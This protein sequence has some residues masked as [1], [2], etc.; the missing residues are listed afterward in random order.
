MDYRELIGILLTWTPYLAE[1][2]TWNVIISIVSMLLG[3]AIG[4]GIAF[5]RVSGAGLLAR[6]AS[7]FTEIC[8]NI[9]TFVFLFYLAFLL[10]A[11][12]PL[13]LGLYLPV[14]AWFKASLALSVAVVGYISDTL[15]NAI[16]DKRQGRPEAMFLFLPAWMTYFLIIVMAS[17][18]A[19]VIG[20]GEVVSR[21]NTVIS[22][23]G[24]QDL[25]VW[26]YVYV[27]SWFFL[28]CWPLAMLM[29]WVQNRIRNHPALMP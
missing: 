7:G 2:F 29:R 6:G 28:F 21:A 17:S 26:I 15:S 3:T 11:E 25:M 24:R 12:V 16:L 14:P 18:T 8:R 20:V 19:S 23:T 1:G 27:M 22:A 10:P 5:A 13:A 4:A 9:P